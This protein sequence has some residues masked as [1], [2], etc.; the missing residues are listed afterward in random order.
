MSKTYFKKV[1]ILVLQSMRS[2]H[3]VQ[4]NTVH[5]PNVTTLPCLSFCLSPCLLVTGVIPEAA[6]F[7]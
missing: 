6:L 2:T 4:Y 7:C 3:T 1:M 5:T